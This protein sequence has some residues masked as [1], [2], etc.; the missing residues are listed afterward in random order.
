[1]GSVEETKEDLRKI[2]ND[3]D[4]DKETQEEA[5]RRLDQYDEEDDE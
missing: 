2:I 1:M 5:Q 4:A 3:P